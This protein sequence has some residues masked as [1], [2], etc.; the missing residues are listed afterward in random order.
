[1]FVCL[2]FKIKNKK[3]EYIFIKIKNINIIMI[4]LKKERV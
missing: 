3:D 4:N 1:M 2:K